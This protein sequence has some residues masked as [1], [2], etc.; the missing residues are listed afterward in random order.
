MD[1]PAKIDPQPDGPLQVSGAIGLYNSR[2]ER[3]ATD[4]K[5]WLC[6]CGGSASKPFCDGTH[7]K[8]GFS[9]ARQLD[10]AKAVTQNYVGKAVTIHDNRAICAHAGFCTDQSPNVFR[11]Q[12]E[13]WIDANADADVLAHTIA[14]IKQ[15]PS[16]A[17]AYS[18]GGQ[19]FEHTG[20]EPAIHIGKD[21][22]YA[23]QGGV[24]LAGDA[25]S[26]SQEHYTLC[27]CGQSK[28][29][30]FCDGSHW[31]AGFKDDKN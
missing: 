17:L 3:I 26:V 28:N 20:R 8:I 19:L 27:R 18:V 23:I 29:K 24:Q 15:C 6:R 2:A 1:V 16:G 4:A 7:K 13:P 25:K 9:S 5:F 14:T 11:M 10:P 30:P 22:P 21:G 12:Q 31:D